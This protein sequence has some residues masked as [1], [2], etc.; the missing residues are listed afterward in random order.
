M[1]SE[2]NLQLRRNTLQ[3]RLMNRLLPDPLKVK[4]DFRDA[5]LT[6]CGGWSALALTAERHPVQP[7]RLELGP[8]AA[9]WR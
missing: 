1:R 5:C 4:Q 3:V 2:L 8:V 9:W 7:L 6:G